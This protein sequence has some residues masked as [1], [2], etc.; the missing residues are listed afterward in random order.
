MFEDIKQ[1]FKQVIKYS[2][3]IED[4]KVDELFDAWLDAKR[5]FIEAFEGNLIYEGPQIE[6]E[7]PEKTKAERV[8]SLTEDVEWVYHNPELADF[9]R[10]N[11]NDMLTSNIVKENYSTETGIIVP[12]GMKVTKAFKLL[13]PNEIALYDIQT[14]ASR[15]IQE[16]KIKGTLCFSVHPLDF[17]SV[18]ENS[19]RWRSC[20]ALDGEYRAGNLSYMTDKTTIVCYLRG[21]NN[22]TIPMFP[23]EVKWNSKKWRMLLFFEKYWNLV[24]AGRQYPFMSTDALTKILPM[25]EEIVQF[26]MTAWTDEYITTFGNKK[27]SKRYFSYANELIA[28]ED[29]VTDVSQLHYNDLLHSSCYDAPFYTMNVSRYKQQKNLPFISVGS[30]VHCLR[31]GANYIRDPETMMCDDCELAFGELENDIFC[32]CPSCNSRFFGDDGIFVGSYDF[33]CPDCVDEQCFYC[34]NCGEYHYNDECQF[35]AT[36]NRYLCCHC[37]YSLGLRDDDPTAKAY[38][39]GKIEF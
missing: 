31:C 39:F 26:K 29:I 2:Q 8:T 13:E 28:L 22:V 16:N 10:V 23:P 15:I 9:I 34:D 19:Y 38:D 25:L 35:D 14:A 33:L 30:K 7:L 27:L 32:T 1:Q 24:I 5:D 20:H 3:R 12:K 4:P 17:L 11:A 6:F 37:A 18:S 36:S 21:E